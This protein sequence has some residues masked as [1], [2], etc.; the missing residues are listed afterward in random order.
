MYHSKRE[1]VQ[2]AVAVTARVCAMFT[3]S[4]VIQ[5]VTDNARSKHATVM[6]NVVP[7]HFPLQKTI[8]EAAAFHPDY[9]LC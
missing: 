9:P 4:I 5:P 6:F 7:L 1:C 2:Q 8:C 3:S